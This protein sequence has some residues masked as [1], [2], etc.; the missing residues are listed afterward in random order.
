MIKFLIFARLHVEGAVGGVLIKLYPAVSWRISGMWDVLGANAARIR[1]PD[2]DY[3]TAIPEYQL[4]V[5][6]R[7]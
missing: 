5:Q 6:G 1:Y 7:I 4:A 3:I 2:Q